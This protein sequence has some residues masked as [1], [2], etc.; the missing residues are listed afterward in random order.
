MKEVE[1]KTKDSQQVMIQDTRI[2]NLGSV[3]YKDELIVD[4]LDQNILSR[5][6]KNA[7]KKLPDVFDNKEAEL[8]YRDFIE[9]WGT[10]SECDKYACNKMLKLFNN[11]LCRVLFYLLKL[12]NAG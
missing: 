12:V 1:R 11:V 9:S 6:F 3:R 7:V 2:C 4:S 10:V 8:E 5:G